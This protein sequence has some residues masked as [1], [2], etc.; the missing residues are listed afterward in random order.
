VIPGTP[1]LLDGRVC[2]CVFKVEERKV[3]Y[4]MI[5]ELLPAAM[6]L[7]VAQTPKEEKQGFVI[8]T[9]EI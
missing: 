9:K 5:L 8:L 4:F 3:F 7:E 1:V 6:V 2:G